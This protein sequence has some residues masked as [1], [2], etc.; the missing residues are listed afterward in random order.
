MTA[1]RITGGCQCGAVRYA[2][3]SAPTYPMICY[4]RM[5]QKQFGNIFGAFAKVERKDFEL[6]RGKLGRFRSS[7]IG[8]RTFCADCGTPMGWDSLDPAKI[9]TWISL[10][11]LD[12]MESVKPIAQWG[13]EGRVSWIAEVIALPVGETGGGD[14]TSDYRNADRIHP[15][16]HP[17]HDTAVWPPA[18]GAS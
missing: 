17:D 1:I 9:E 15:R 2:L 10:G 5:C 12:D 7:D 4:C 3:H 18:A 16:T 11:S 8:V 6:T 14:V 13:S